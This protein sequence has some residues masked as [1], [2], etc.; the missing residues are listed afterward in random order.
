[1]PA[2]SPHPPPPSFQVCYSL[3]LPGN[4][5]VSVTLLSSDA[6][7][8][9]EGR[10][11]GEAD[12]P[13]LMVKRYHVTAMV[14]GGVGGSPVVK[15]DV[16]ECVC[17]YASDLT[18]GPQ[19]DG[20][21]MWVEGGWRLGWEWRADYDLWSASTS[22]TDSLSFCSYP[23]TFTCIHSFMYSFVYMITIMCCERFHF[24]C[25]TFVQSQVSIVNPCV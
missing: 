1:M 9:Q 13:N 16:C 19:L 8:V 7:R 6:E 21:H 20:W 10:K 3:F 5:T 15:D 12:L 23:C 2:P 24:R 18:G 25:R 4:Y 22:S 17:M 11:A 14:G